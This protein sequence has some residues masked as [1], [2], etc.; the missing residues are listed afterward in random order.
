MNQ[1]DKNRLESE[2]ATPQQLAPFIALD[3]GTIRLLPEIRLMIPAVYFVFDID[4]LIYVGASG[5]VANRIRDYYRDRRY[6]RL[7]WTHISVLPVPGDIKF[8]IERHY[9]EKLHPTM[10]GINEHID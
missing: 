6:G 9:I 2:A 1:I 5:G 8:T 4:E 10:N 3:V 7:Q